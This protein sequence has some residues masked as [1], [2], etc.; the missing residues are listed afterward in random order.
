M[1]YVH[2]AG[3]VEKMIIPIVYSILQVYGIIEYK[4]N[5]D[6]DNQKEKCPMS[7]CT[8]NEMETLS[9]ES[10]NTGIFVCTPPPSSS[11]EKAYIYIGPII[12]FSLSHL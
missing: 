11:T 10:L 8:N 3:I 5:R 4:S 9:A 12:R 2:K 7:L 6:S 1:P